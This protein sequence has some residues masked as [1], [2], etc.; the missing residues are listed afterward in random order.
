MTS[1]A[2][3]TANGEVAAVTAARPG[4]RV[5]DRVVVLTSPWT[6]RPWNAVSVVPVNRLP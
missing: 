1:T 6:S 5:D 2:A 4:D 3:M